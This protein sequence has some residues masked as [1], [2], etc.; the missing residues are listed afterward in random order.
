MQ[1]KIYIFH[2]SF[3]ADYLTFIN[4][5]ILYHISHH[6]HLVKGFHCDY[7]FVCLD[8]NIGLYMEGNDDFLGC[9]IDVS[10]YK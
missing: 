5:N 2:V 4:E 3:I 8:I 9:A 10:L 7:I 6:F 1:G